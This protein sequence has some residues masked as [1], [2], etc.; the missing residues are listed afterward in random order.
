VV[1]YISRCYAPLC[2]TTQGKTA[3]RRSFSEAH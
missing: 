3:V 1:S 2:R